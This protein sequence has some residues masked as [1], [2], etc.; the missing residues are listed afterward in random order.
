MNEIKTML[1]N[2]SKAQA[3][4]DDLAVV[5]TSQPLQEPMQPPSPWGISN[6]V[7][8]LATDLVSNEI[9]IIDDQNKLSAIVIPAIENEALKKSQMKVIN[10]AVMQSKVSIR[11]SFQKKN[12]DTV[13]GFC[14]T[15][16]I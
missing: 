13:T 2:Q 8:P 16:T 7:A 5:S 10:N 6:M 3:P 1:R 9:N 14:L 12:G 11:N 4:K 15:D